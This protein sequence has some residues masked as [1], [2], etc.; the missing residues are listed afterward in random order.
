MKITSLTAHDVRFPTSRVARRL[1]RHAHA[2]PTTRRRTSSCAPTRARSSRGTGSPSRAGAAT[3]SASPPSGR[4]SLS[5]S[6]AASRESR[7]TCAVFWRSLVSDGQLRWLGPEKGVVH[8]A[9][10]AVVNAVWDLWAKSRGVPLWRL[11]LDLEPDELVAAID[12]RYIDDALTRTR[13]SSCSAPGRRGGRSASSSS[14]EA[15]VPGVHDVGRLARLRRR[16]GG[17]TRA[18]G[19]RRR[20]PPREDE[21]GRRT[22]TTMSR[23]AALIR[24]VAR[25]RRLPDDGRE[26]GLGRRRGDRGDAAC[27]R[28]FD[29]WWIEEPTSPDDVLGH[30]RIRRGDRADPG[31]DRGG[32]PE[33]RHLQAAVPGGGDRRLPDRRLPRRRA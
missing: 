4:S 30:A 19:G 6:A 16:E 22:S 29:P 20:V 3:R 26:P 33:P 32:R 18:A 5:S 25:R 27:S 24:D 21:G 9:V 14:C 13:P 2:A 11:L 28:Q 15:R 7:A 17:R 10:G 8:L 31:R 23:R 12:F 1:R